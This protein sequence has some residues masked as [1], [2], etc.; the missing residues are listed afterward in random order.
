MAKS[1]GNLLIIDDDKDVLE[2][3]NMFLKYE[4]SKVITIRNPNRIHELIKAENIDV[5]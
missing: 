3:L 1:E 2:S 4:F 5:I